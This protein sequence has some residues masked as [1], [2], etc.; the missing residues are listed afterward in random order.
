M[1]ETKQLSIG[2]EREMEREKR[3][4]RHRHTDSHLG[5]RART[6][7]NSKSRANPRCRHPMPL[8]SPHC[9]SMP[10]LPDTQCL[11]FQQ[12]K[13]LAKRKHKQNKPSGLSAHVDTK[14]SSTEL[15]CHAFH[16]TLLTRIHDVISAD[17][18]VVNDH[19]P[20]P[21]CNC[22][23]LQ[24]SSKDACLHVSKSSHK[25]RFTNTSKQTTKQQQNHGVSKPSSLQSEASHQGPSPSATRGAQTEKKCPTVRDMYLFVEGQHRPTKKAHSHTKATHT[26]TNTQTHKTSTQKP[27][28]HTHTHST[29]RVN[30]G[31]AGAGSGWLF[32]WLCL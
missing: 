18:T 32:L 19:V 23:P 29:R 8:C 2:Q 9:L 16:E 13:K 25:P 14:L 22:V 21:E 11:V 15:C 10:D 24:S 27:H 20:S 3:A 1:S 26:H 28:T 30:L 6:Q 12:R 7:N 31:A 5:A 17:G 4:H